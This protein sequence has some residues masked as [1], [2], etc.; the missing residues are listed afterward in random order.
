MR[1]KPII[2]F[3]SNRFAFYAVLFLAFLQCLILLVTQLPLLWLNSSVGY[4]DSYILGTLGEFRSTGILYPAWGPGHW[5][6]SLYSPLLYWSLSLGLALAHAENA[7][8][9]P[10]VLE[11]IWFVGAL[12]AASL[13]TTRLIP[14][15]R[16][17]P[18]AML[19]AVSFSVMTEWVLQLRGDF[20]GIICSLLAL[21]FLMSRRQRDIW[22]AGLFA[23]LATQFKLTLIA[24]A[25]AGF[26]WLIFNRRWADLVRFMIPATVM[27]FGL[28]AV[29]AWHEPEMLKSIMIMRKMI[30]HTLGV[31][32][33]FIQVFEEPPF[34]LGVAILLGLLVP[35]LARP[36]P[37]WQL[38]TIFLGCSFAIATYTSRQS[39]ANVNYFYESLLALTPFVVLGMLR[40]RSGRAR[41]MGIFLGLVL[42]LSVKPALRS[43]QAG[44]GAIAKV[45]ERNVGLGLIRAALEGESV[46]SILP[47]V[48]APLKGQVVS[49]PF[50]LNYL[51][52]S[53]GAD[54]TPLEARIRKDDF[55]L[56]V[57]YPGNYSY[58][59]VAF[60][61]DPIRT[62][63]MDSY[64]P[65]CRLGGILFH[66]PN[67]RL[68]STEMVEERLKELVCE[69][70]DTA[71]CPGLDETI[72]QFQF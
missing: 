34:L 20:P 18:L 49:E 64:H 72:E 3:L 62:A 7:Y 60:M 4:G 8:I 22:L 36:Y 41:S 43:L 63:I 45:Q 46:L 48:T 29:L 53:T 9:G 27:S 21:Y 59:G 11:L 47:D 56:V 70:C 51:I 23:G 12:A 32:K 10:R 14:A 25:A 65:H 6:P 71:K 68:A 61:P 30:P 55:D 39:G 17:F 69:R 54:V 37:R 15:R 35:M 33:F 38:L 24:P 2:R 57:T 5:S 40:L 58:R 28:Y 44:V 16:L 67:K 66:L 31:V 26:L 19:M 13:V 1:I 52:L 42:L 50:L